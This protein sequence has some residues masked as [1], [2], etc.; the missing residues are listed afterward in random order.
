[1][2]LGLEERSNIIFKK[3]CYG[4][5]QKVLRMHNAKNCTN[6]KVCKVCYSKHPTTLHGLVLR[7]GNSQKKPEK[8]NFE[9][10]SENENVSGNDR[11]N[12]CISE[13]R[14]SSYKYECSAC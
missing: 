2:K 1:M 3:K 6:R 8:Q 14:F 7:K 11:F 5:F 4:C 10:T 13:Y 9:E 12:M